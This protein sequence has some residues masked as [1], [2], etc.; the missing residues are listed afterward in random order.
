[1]PQLTCLRC[2]KKIAA[3]V[4]KSEASFTLCNTRCNLSHS[5]VWHCKQWYILNSNATCFAMAE[6]ARSYLV[7]TVKKLIISSHCP[8]EQDETMLHSGWGPGQLFS[9][10][11]GVCIAHARLESLRLINAE[12]SVQRIYT[13]SSKNRIIKSLNKLDDCTFS[14]STLAY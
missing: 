12:C 14:T 10:D 2:W 9:D 6:I 4:G 8:F 11:F 1:M 13:H 7:Q 5:N 3:I